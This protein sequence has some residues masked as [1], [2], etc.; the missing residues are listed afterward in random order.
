MARDLRNSRSGRLVRQLVALGTA[1]AATVAFTSFAQPASAND[2]A[3]DR[4]RAEHA[5]FVQTNDPGGN[6]VIA[7][8]RAGDG[9]LTRLTTYATGGLGGTQ[10]GAVVDPLASQGSLT[11][12]GVHH[13]LFAVNAGSDTFTVFRVRGAELE[14]L[15]VIGSRGHLPTSV[16]V[17]G[18]VVY[19]LNAGYDGAISG[20]RIR[21]GSHVVPIAESTRTLGL[22]NPATPFFLKSPSQVAVT[23]DR[24]AVIVATKVAGT[25]EVFPL[26]HQ[27]LPSGSPVITASAAPVPFALVFDSA[28]R[29]LVTEASG[30][31]SSYVVNA[32]GTLSII[33]SHVANGQTAGCWSVVAK[34]YVY[35]ANSGSATITGYSEDASGH[36]ALLNADGVTATTGAGPVDLAVSG[37]KYLYQLS[38]GSGVIDEFLVNNNG[39]L[40]RIGTL[41]GFPPDNGTG[42]EGIAAF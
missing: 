24:T 33:S 30:G 10:T 14:R 39:S 16:S 40:T 31:E 2:G 38:T 29:L 23:P 6:A 19:V 35:V 18:E 37:D 41:T 21:G 17:S 13:L 42:Y 7:Y 9:S 28:G 32:D 1:A 36:L 5:V 12:D 22:G 20:F 15:D 34:G 11:Y 25:L 26:N 3:G 27:G 4:S 8:R